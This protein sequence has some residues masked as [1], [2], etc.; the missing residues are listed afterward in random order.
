MKRNPRSTREV[1]DSERVISRRELKARRSQALPPAAG[2]R[3]RNHSAGLYRR[4]DHLPHRQLAQ[5]AFCRALRCRAGK[6]FEDFWNEQL[7]RPDNTFKPLSRLAGY[8][9]AARQGCRRDGERLS[10]L[11]FAVRVNIFS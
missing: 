9:L 5:L 6:E 4:R 8:R 3:R 11:R 1:L 7:L 2:S 10:T